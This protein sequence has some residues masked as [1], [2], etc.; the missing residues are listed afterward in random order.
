[1]PQPLVVGPISSAGLGRIPWFVPRGAP[2]TVCGWR[3]YLV[4]SMG[5]TMNIPLLGLYWDSI[6]AMCQFRENGGKCGGHKT[7]Q[8]SR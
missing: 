7:S 5:R 1:M 8:A 2:D 6:S 3:G 4:I